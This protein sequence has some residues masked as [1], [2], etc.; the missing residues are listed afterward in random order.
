MIAVEVAALCVLLLGAAW[1]DL[2]CSRVK[3]SWLLCGLAVGAGLRGASFLAAASPALL[4]VFL[5]YC[6]GLMGAGDGKL[7]VCI[8][9]YLGLRDGF[10][11][12][13]FGMAVGAVWSLCILLYYKS[14]I[15][16]L[17]YLYAWFRQRFQTKIWIAYVPPPGAHG[18]GTIPLAACL[19]AGTYLYLL[20][21]HCR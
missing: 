6:L 15:T 17:T 8:A 4:L 20:L 14:L 21:M 13:G 10:A 11:A 9:G 18:E 7:I 12:V 3:N 19:A 5:L 1:T 2:T 16:R